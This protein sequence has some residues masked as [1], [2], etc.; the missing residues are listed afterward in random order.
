[1][2]EDRNC[3]TN[4][5]Q[6]ACLVEIQLIASFQTPL[7]VGDDCL[8]FG[9]RHDV[10][11]PD[12]GEVVWKRLEQPIP[13]FSHLHTPP[14]HEEHFSGKDFSEFSEGFLQIV[15]FQRCQQFGPRQEVP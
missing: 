15:T 2:V 5:A 13:R 7:T 3:I 12:A 1:M 8:H 10:R 11:K 4:I 9:R 14:K 6:Q